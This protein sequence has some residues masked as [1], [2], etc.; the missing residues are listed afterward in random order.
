MRNKPNGNITFII[1]AITI[2]FILFLHLF[3]IKWAKI[4][5]AWACKILSSVT[6]TISIRQ[7]LNTFYKSFIQNHYLLLLLLLLLLHF[8]FYRVFY[9]RLCCKKKYISL[10]LSLILIPI[11]YKYLE[12]W[13]WKVLK[14]VHYLLRDSVYMYHIKNC[15]KNFHGTWYR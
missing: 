7:S 15:W 10:S 11:N 8:S 12:L 5:T 4:I 14:C 1:I 3:Y 9:I 6:I 2:L 13:Q